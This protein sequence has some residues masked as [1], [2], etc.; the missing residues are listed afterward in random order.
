MRLLAIMGA[1]SARD[2]ELI[3]FRRPDYVRGREGSGDARERNGRRED[4]VASADDGTYERQLGKE[5]SNGT[6]LP[7]SA[8]GAEPVL[9]EQ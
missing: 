7:V 8:S 6:A 1:R 4:H 9:F 3:P 5:P 2:P